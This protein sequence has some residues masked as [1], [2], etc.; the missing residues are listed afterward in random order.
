MKNTLRILMAVGSFGWF[1]VGQEGQAATISYVA[2]NIADTTIG[3]DLW[4]YDYAVTGAV[5]GAAESFEIYFD[6]SLFRGLVA[7][8]APTAEWDVLVLQQ[9]NPANIAPFDLGIF[10]A[11]A[12][13]GNPSLSGVFSVTF[14]YLGATAPG[15]QAFKIFNDDFSVRQEAQTV[16]LSAGAIPEPSTFGLVALAGVAVAATN[17]RRRLKQVRR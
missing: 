8:P 7:G 1:G 9:P 3:E 10:N 12:L 13:Q 14:V 15:A 6:A 16:P 4:R 17:G 2:T 11:F 5:F